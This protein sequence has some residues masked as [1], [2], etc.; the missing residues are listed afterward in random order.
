MYVLYARQG[1]RLAR[2]ITFDPSGSDSSSWFSADYAVASDWIDLL[3]EDK[4]FF[5]INGD[6]TYGKF[7]LE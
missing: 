4:N 2:Y 6:E 1:N 7:L 3:S 5:S